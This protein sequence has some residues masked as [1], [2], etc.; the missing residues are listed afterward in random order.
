MILFIIMQVVQFTV[1]HL[2]DSV[3]SLD[4]HIVYQFLK[5]N[6]N[7]LLS[8]QVSLKFH[9]RYSWAFN[10]Y[11]IGTQWYITILPGP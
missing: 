9:L 10:D 7:Q 4:S 8:L 5:T 6:Q 2:K 1:L 3:C 11:C